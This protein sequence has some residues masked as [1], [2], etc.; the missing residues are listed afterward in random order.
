MKEMKN[1]NL[2]NENKIEKYQKKALEEFNQNEN[3]IQQ[4]IQLQQEIIYL[5]KLK[6]KK[7][8]ELQK[9]NLYQ[10][11]LSNVAKIENNT[12]EDDIDKILKRY[13]ILIY[14]IKELNKE[15]ENKKNLIK[16]VNNDYKNFQKQLQNQLFELNATLTLKRSLLD[17]I[18]GKIQHV[19]IHHLKQETKYIHYTQLYSKVCMSI[20]NLQERCEDTRKY[21]SGGNLI[22]GNPNT[23]LMNASMNTTNNLLNKSNAT[24]DKKEPMIDLLQ[25][26]KIRLSDVEYIVQILNK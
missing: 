23:N 17:K 3:K 25:N 16:Q 26:I 2:V 21:K 6:Y 8:K 19:E 1:F 22:G 15:I 12:F 20:R 24:I 18:K 11:Y 5:C 14:S 4:I 9:I 7:E 10:N 13:E